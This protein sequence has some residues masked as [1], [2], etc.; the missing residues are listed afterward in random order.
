[1]GSE[2]MPLMT[3][4]AKTGLKL[5]IQIQNFTSKTPESP[6]SSNIRK[7]CRTP[8]EEMLRNLS[9]TKP[10]LWHNSLSVQTD[11]IQAN[12]ESNLNHFAQGDLIQAMKHSDLKQDNNTESDMKQCEA[13]QS[14]S[15]NNDLKRQ[16][17]KDYLFN[18]SPVFNHENVNV[19]QEKARM[20]QENLKHK[21]GQS[22][23]VEFQG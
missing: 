5:S 3:R 4:V 19:W 10:E 2:K 11:S 22:T 9:V 21:I 23:K 12:S 7:S 8:S 13:N 14:K 6:V 17:I 15:R 16:T 18:L 20:E 1:M